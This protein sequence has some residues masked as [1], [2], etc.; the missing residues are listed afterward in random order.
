[1]SVDKLMT[2]FD[3]GGY[4]VWVWTAYGVSIFSLAAML[5]VSLRSLRAREREF[6]TL[7]SARGGGRPPSFE[8]LAFTAREGE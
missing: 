4:A 2:F 5:V 3:M 7:R 6:E 1:M 8:S